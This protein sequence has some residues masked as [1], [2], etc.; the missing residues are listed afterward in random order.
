MTLVAELDALSQRIKLTSSWVHKDSIR[1]IPG[2]KWDA[3]EKVWDLPL[4]FAS[5]VMLRAS[6]GADLMIGSTLRGWAQFERETRID[7]ALVLRATLA[8]PEDNQ[9]EVAKVIRS[10]R[11][12][13]AVQLYPYQESGAAFLLDAQDALLADAM[14]TGKSLT[15]LSAIRA[16]DELGRDPFPVLVVT[17]NSVKSQWASE[18]WR[19]LPDVRPYVIAGSAVKRRKLLAEAATDPRAVVILN[20]EAVRTM[21]RLAPYGSIR[22]LRCLDCAKPHHAT[23]GEPVPESR[24][25][26]HPKEL[27]A[28]PFRT[29]ILDEGHRVKD[30]RAKQ[31]RAIWSVFHGPTVQNRYVLTG[32]PV[33]NHPGDLW[34]LMHAVAPSDYQT[35][36][37]FVERF[38]QVSWNG[39]G[40]EI[41]GLRPE[42]RAELFRFLDP[43]MRRVTKDLVLKQLPPKVYSVRRVEMS[44]KQAKAYKSLE[45]SAFAELDVGQRLVAATNLVLGTRLLQLANSYCS[46]SY[47]DTPEDYSSWEVTPTEPS[48]KID[49]LMAIIEELDGAPVAVAAE[50][51]RLLDLVA[52]RLAKHQVPYVE[53]TG[54]VQEHQ[55]ALNLA[56][57]QEGRV[58]I[59]LFTLKAGGVGLNMTRAG[60]LVR[61]QRSWSLVD[62]LQASDRVHRIGSEQHESVNIID[63]VT[64]QTIEE[65]QLDSLLLKEERLEQI[66]RDREARRL[67]GLDTA[68]LDEQEAGLLASGLI[69]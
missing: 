12:T 69:D 5:C 59:L 24:C 56:K 54:A 20:I 6:F 67:H 21:S 44:P 30:P 42:R 15:S 4:S 29:C 51:R 22:L 52:A 31:T 16:A 65:E 10:W 55:R 9:S 18:V 46:I 13:G 50:H 37:K 62:N 68:E 60:T 14:G 34:S 2:S 64:D 49:E 17:P 61:L 36:S 23:D 57:F 1:S 28:I 26:A 66:N 35:R 58:P 25:E 33:A 40:M 48:P 38:A 8:L 11:G 47:G 43:R 45:D 53:I 27:N 32:T 7:P 63:I 19:W 3:A 39:F 41:L